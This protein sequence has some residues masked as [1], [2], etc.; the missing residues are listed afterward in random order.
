MFLTRLTEIKKLENETVR[1]FNAKFEKLLQQIPKIH[2][3]GG[4]YLLFLYIKDFQ[5][6]FGYFLKDKGPK[7]THEAK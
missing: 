5:G 4:Y 7:T 3:P 2:H 6:H 1:E